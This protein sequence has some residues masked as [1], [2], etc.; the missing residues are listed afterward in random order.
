MQLYKIRQNDNIYGA[1]R[2]PLLPPGTQTT[3]AIPAELAILRLILASTTERTLERAGL[4]R[5]E[6]QHRPVMKPSSPPSPCPQTSLQQ[7][8]PSKLRQQHPQRQHYSRPSQQLALRE[9]GSTRKWTREPAGRKLR[10]ALLRARNQWRE[11][12]VE[13]RRNM[14]NTQLNV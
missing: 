4:K 9:A 2:A 1:A 8:Y 10:K 5:S 3:C 6:N 7:P 11:C 13:I 12:D 14:A